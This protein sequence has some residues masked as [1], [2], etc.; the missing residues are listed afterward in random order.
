MGVDVATGSVGPLIET[1]QEPAAL[2]FDGRFLWVVN[3][4]D[5]TLLRLDHKTKVLLWYHPLQ[6]KMIFDTFKCRQHILDRGIPWQ[7]TAWR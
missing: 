4:A 2:A 5:Q 1:G 3:A 6:Q 7:V